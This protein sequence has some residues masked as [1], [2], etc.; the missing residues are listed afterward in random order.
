M[1]AGT[2]QYRLTVS[3]DADEEFSRIFENTHTVRSTITEREARKGILRDIAGEWNERSPLV[4]TI[5]TILKT[6]I[7]PSQMGAGTGHIG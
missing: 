6:I 7:V 3:Y 1:G 2:G 4:S 5:S